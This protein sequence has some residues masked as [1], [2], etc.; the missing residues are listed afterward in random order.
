MTFIQHSTFCQHVRLLGAG[1]K[2]LRRGLSWKNES[3][4]GSCCGRARHPQWRRDPTRPCGLGHQV[5]AVNRSPPSCCSDASDLGGT[6]LLIF[7]SHSHVYVTWTNFWYYIS[8]QYSV[9]LPDG[10]FPY[11][12][13]LPNRTMPEGAGSQTLFGSV[14]ISWR[15][16]EDTSVAVSPAEFLISRSLESAFLITSTLKKKNH[17][18]NKSVER[19]M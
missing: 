14:R 6:W 7:P 13:L 16:C 18:R 9:A 8:S 5:Q 19:S 3:T 15:A 4:H 17:Q 12:P 11:H 1:P 10:S 2:S